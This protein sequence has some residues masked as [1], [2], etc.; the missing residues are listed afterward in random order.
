[1]KPCP[2]CGYGNSDQNNKCGICARD[3]TAVQIRTVPQP[4]RESKLIL[5]T[6]LLLLACG[7]AYY[8][9]TS[10]VK[11]PRSASAG[12]AF[13]DE[14]SFSYDGVAYALDKMDGLRFLPAADRR[15]VLKLLA[16]PDDRV[17]MAAARLAGE[18]VRSAEDPAEAKLFYDAL[19]RT[20][21]S[22]SRIARR[23][24]ALQ[25]GLAAAAG[26]PASPYLGEIRKVSSGLAA[27]RDP[28]LTAAGFLL[29]STAG[30]EDFNGDMLNTLRFDPSAAARL[31]AAC[32]LA[33]LGSAEGGRHLAKLAAGGDQELSSE[34]FACLTYSF[35]PE[36]GRFLS[37]TVRGPD[38]D[39]AG[40]ARMVLIL[41]K[42]L[43]IIKK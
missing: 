5:L 9:S 6:G 10:L 14:A 17:V 36:T 18:W 19:L 1:M 2:S 24:A 12:T 38:P 40:R 27:T 11:P 15:N 20:A 34:A 29:A 23:S 42:Q 31:Y 43:A 13:S 3:I 21:A 32:G 25:A 33:R 8:I 30:I 35:A 22:G 4:Q 16:C 37:E 26:F 7:A 39:L 28:E 41:R